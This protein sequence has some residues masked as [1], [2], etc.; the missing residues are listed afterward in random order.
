MHLLKTINRKKITNKDAIAQKTKKKICLQKK[1]HY[2]VVCEEG[3]LATHHS[4]N[5]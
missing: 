3:Y 4:K 5:T 2:R 1:E